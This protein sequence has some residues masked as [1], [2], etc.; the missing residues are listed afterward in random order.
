MT[1]DFK[2]PLPTDPKIITTEINRLR[3]SG[4]PHHARKLLELTLAD[5]RHETNPFFLNLAGFFLLED[6]KPAEARQF[7]EYTL[8]MHPGYL[9]ALKGMVQSYRLDGNRSKEREFN[10]KVIESVR[11]TS[12][13]NRTRS[14]AAH[15]NEPRIASGN[16]WRLIPN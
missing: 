8:G 16:G 13:T 5:K 9:P 4:M 11:A 6:R 10:D 12:G 7:F 2:K 1:L 3:Y 14:V 15:S